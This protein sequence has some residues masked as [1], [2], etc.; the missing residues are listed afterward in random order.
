MTESGIVAVRVE[1]ATGA[2]ESVAALARVREAWAGA[3]L[4]A[5]GGEVDDHMQLWLLGELPTARA[6]DAAELARIVSE[7]IGDAAASLDACAGAILSEDQEGSPDPG[8]SPWVMAIPYDVPAGEREEL[9]RWY[10]EEHTEL[11]LRSR[12]WLRVRRVAVTGA[13]GVPWNRLIVHDLSSPDVIS[14]PDVVRSMQTP[15]RRALAE[16]PWFLQGG[17]RALR[18]L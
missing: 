13:D 15:W 11:L 1:Y 2:V 14:D 8:G 3:T 5:W 4:D 6:E 12:D 7:A 16:R 18:R 9:D 10:M 17:R